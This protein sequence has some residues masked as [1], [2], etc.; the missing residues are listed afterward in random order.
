[1]ARRATL[2]A[3]SVALA[4]G[5][6][7]CGGGVSKPDFVTKAD[8]ACGAGNGTLAGVAKPTNLPE[9]ATAAGSVVAMVDGQADAL[10]KLDPPGDDKAVVAGV[11]SALA[12]VSGPARALQEAAGKGD[13]AGTALAANELKGKT[14]NA[15]AQ[16]K[17][18]GLTACGQGLQTPVATV[19]DGGRTVLKAAFVARADALCT[20]ANR[21]AEAIAS[22]TSF[23]SLARYLGAYVPIEEKLFADI[24]AL[25]APPGDDSAIAEMLGAQD[26]VIAKDKELLAAAQRRNEKE[27][28]RLDAEETTLV[29]AANAKFDAYGLR[30]CGT[31]SSF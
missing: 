19:I 31:L 10:R 14:D 11:I 2:F 24:R 25:T 29:T 30:V 21:K 17:A 9:L 13:D 4:A 7:A 27:F 12:E 23:A 15:A 16:A 20:A 8:G 6:V 22:P 3:A 28:D 5:L 1:M 18:Y 26:K